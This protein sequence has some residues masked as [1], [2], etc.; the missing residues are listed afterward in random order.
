MTTASVSLGLASEPAST[1]AEV[2]EQHLDYMRQALAAA[3]AATVLGEVPVG[4][5]VVVDGTVIAVAH[6]ER[7]TGNDPTAHAEV[8]AL[9]R[10][11][12]TLGSWRLTGADLY[13]TMEPCPMCAGA[14]VNARLRR[15]YYGC[16]D[17]K[18]GAVRS[19]YQILDDRRLNHRVEVVPG[20]LGGEAAGLLRGFFERLRR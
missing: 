20:V 18:A 11:A 15:V 5:V 2:A 10:A 8:L 4:A 9:R 19:L 7:E 12:A 16:H 13:V 14:I 1:P 17:P 3:Q 6:N